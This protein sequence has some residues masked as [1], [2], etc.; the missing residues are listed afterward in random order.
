VK[1]IAFAIIVLY[2]H[3]VSAQSVGIGTSTPHASARLQISSSTQG[4]LIPAMTATQ[5][6]AI[7]NPATGLMVFQSDGTQGFYYYAGS[8]WVNLTSGHVA[9]NEGTALSR[10]YGLTY[11]LAGNGT[12]DDVDAQGSGAS[13]DHPAGVAVDGAGNVYVADQFNNKIRKITPTGLVSTFAG[14]GAAGA[15]NGPR[16]SATFDHPID[17]TL[18]AFGNLYVADRNNNRIRKIAADGMVSTLAGSSEG[19][20]DAL[21]E[22]AQFDRPAGIAVDPSGN[23]Y[24]ADESNHRVRKITPAGMVS[25]VAGSSSFGYVNGP[26]SAARFTGIV[27]VV[28]DAAGNIYAV[29]HQNNVIRKIDLVNGLVSTFAG[30]LNRESGNQDGVG[31]AARFSSPHGLAIDLYGNLYVADRG[32]H[33][34]RKITPAREVSTLSGSGAFGDEDGAGGVATFIQPVRLTTDAFGDVY[35]ADYIG[36]R[37]RKIIAH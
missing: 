25:T 2:T 31:N 32:N 13:F 4:I 19:F 7:S 8:G 6:N 35:V 10:Y 27:D 26:I 36:S 33:R 3:A 24:V 16:L 1:K 11:T 34:I 15:G 12:D 30:D 23:V 17:I 9:N 18:D 14:T 5:R 20:A 22:L 21:G 28:L 37:I 29:E